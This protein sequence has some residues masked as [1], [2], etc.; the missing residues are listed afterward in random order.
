MQLQA[1]TMP[2]LF[3]VYSTA[4]AALINAQLDRG[5]RRYQDAQNRFHEVSMAVAAGLAAALLLALGA[6]MML[7]RAIVDPVNAAI[8]NFNRISDGDL[9][10][11]IVVTSDNEMGKLSAALQK[12]QDSLR[13]AISAVRGSTESINVGVNEIAAGNTA[14]T[15]RDA[16]VVFKVVGTGGS[17]SAENPYR[18]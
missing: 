9:T 1:Y 6:R 12:M 11:R 10:G 16:V 4:M 3:N 17:G 2:K 8:G 5:A 14:R 13:A 7:M 15:R 18:V